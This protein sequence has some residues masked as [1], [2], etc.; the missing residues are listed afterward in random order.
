MTV[1]EIDRHH[2]REESGDMYFSRAERNSD[3]ADALKKSL[4]SREV[5][6]QQTGGTGQKIPDAKAEEAA[7]DLFHLLVDP[8]NAELRP[9]NN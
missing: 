9:E 2:R 6:L 4:L 7:Y 1:P 8:I 5:A 3:G